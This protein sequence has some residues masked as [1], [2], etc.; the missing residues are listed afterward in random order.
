MLGEGLLII[1]IKAAW[2]LRENCDEPLGSAV[3]VE[4]KIL[5]R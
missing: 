3:T 5:R 2:R 1:G 4:R